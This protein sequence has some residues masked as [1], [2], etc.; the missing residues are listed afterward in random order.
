M[1]VLLVIFMCT[2]FFLIG[3]V[4]GNNE[5]RQVGEPASVVDETLVVVEEV[6]VSDSPEGFV[7]D[8][9]VSLTLTQKTASFLEGLVNGIYTVIV[10]VLHEIAS[11]FF[12]IH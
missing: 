8:K 4:F 7:Y 12:S 11:I 10:D 5:A 6:T 3:I 1:R 2:T 9:P